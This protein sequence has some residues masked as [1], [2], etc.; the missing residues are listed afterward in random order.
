MAIRHLHIG[1]YRSLR[2]VTLELTPLTVVLGANGTGKSNLYGALRVIARAARGEL[3]R[4]LAE[5]GGM[6]SILWAGGERKR[7]TRAKP[8]VRVAFE[9]QLDDVGYALELGLPIPSLTLFQRD[10]EV[11][12]EAVWMGDRRRPSTMLLERKAQAAHLVD[13]AHER[14]TY[15]PGLLAG[16]SVLAQ[17]V[18][19]RRFPE[20]A[21][22]R[23]VLARWRFH[24]HFRTDAGA[25]AR[26]PQVGVRTPVLG[27]GGDD[28]AA[29]LQT[30]VEIGDS[31]ALAAAIDDAFPGASL[32]VVEQRGWF[33]LELDLPG[34]LRPLAAREL[35]DGTLRY[36][37]LLAALSSPRPP[38]FLVLNEPETSLHPDLLPPLAR[39]IVAAAAH[40]QVLCTT[41]SAQLAD[42]LAAAPGASRVELSLVDGETRL[43]A[44]D[45][46]R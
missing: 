4:A 6:P 19:P 30:I 40:C 34:I 3:A 26:Q 28:L 37:C 21:H 23:D 2:D 15:P 5:E 36:L 1:G 32:R 13:D 44:Q 7:L 45:P 16:E 22:L 8:P 9:V 14:V 43:A 11:K 24:H 33:E 17:V 27:D 12:E 35:S 10:P 25:P 18:D 42:L 31:D 39:C 20:L 38:A 29:A 46:K 41:H